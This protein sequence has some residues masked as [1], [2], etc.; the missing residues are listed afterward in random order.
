MG[1][2]KFL[3][4]LL[5]SSII[6]NGIFTWSNPAFATTGCSSKSWVVSECTGAQTSNNSVDVWA[7]STTP[8][9]TTPAVAP[10]TRTSGNRQALV[11]PVF[12]P[13]SLAF[14]CLGFITPSPQCQK[15][16]V[17]PPAPVTYA[18]ITLADL[19][20]FV[21]QAATLTSQPRGWSVVNLDTNFI[22]GATTHIVGGSLL[23]ASA[24]VRFTP[25]AYDWNYGDG[26]TQ[27]TSVPGS[28]WDALGL[29]E[30]SPTATSHVYGSE[31]SFTTTVSVRY[32]AEYR[33][34]GGAWIPVAGEVSSAATTMV[35]I[36]QGADTVLA[37]RD[38]TAS[39]SAPG[40]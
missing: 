25:H 32:G 9:G 8:G 21:P 3:L 26:G 15:T 31:G 24:E 17:A 18:P 11:R 29:R 6:F 10:A 22:A 23:G 5:C 38:C 4:S 34:G 13:S 7:R 36:I 27:T 37:A 40:C 20:N 35:V 14:R 16:P 2:N 28:R 1:R 19:A 12:F 30:F 39:R 33:V